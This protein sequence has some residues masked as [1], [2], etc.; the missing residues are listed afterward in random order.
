MKILVVTQYFWPESF[1]VVNDLIHELAE[2]GHDVHVLT[3]KP[4]YPDGKIFPGYSSGGCQREMYGDKVTVI[5]VPLR[6]R[7]NG[8]GKNMVLNYLSFVINAI[9]Y[10]G[11]VIQGEKYDVVFA[12]ALSPITA[13]IPAVF[14]KRRLKAPLVVWVQ[15]LWPESLSAT[16]FIKNKSVL[17]AVGAMVRWIYSSCDR[18]LV[19]SRGFFA[20]IS[21][22]ADPA[23]L[24]YY[25]NSYR[26]PESASED[27]SRIPPEI[28]RMMDSNF[29][30]LFA[31]NIGTAQAVETIVEAAKKLL[32]LPDFKLV[33]VGSGSMLGWVE[34]QKKQ[35]NLDNL[36]LAGRYPASEMPNFFRRAQVL[37]VSL[38][39]EEIFAYT[40]P[41]KI[42]AYFAAGRPIIAALDGEGAQ[43]VRE[44]GA[45]LV[46]GAED[47]PGLCACVEQLYYMDAEARQGL[48]D[49]GRRYFL[50]HFEMRKQAAELSRHLAAVSEIY[51]AR[52]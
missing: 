33:M 13:V 40:V 27:E 12:I 4:N 44:A 45:G 19:Q 42:Q 28:L 50:E 11:K 24:E 46:C 25:P 8:G 38:K 49:A 16:G 48:A 32:H 47:V 51:N 35:H 5:R 52:H 43:V 23:K 30:V 1:V 17:G 36:I 41:S 26:E 20:P 10:S 21:R 6:A 31:G 39:R 3:G 29:C 15:D 18:I 37:L 2:Q 22:F 7:G 9:R 14:L 34:K